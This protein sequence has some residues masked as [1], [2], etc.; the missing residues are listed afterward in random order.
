M[1]KLLTTSIF[2]MT[3][4]LRRGHKGFVLTP[5]LA[6]M[7]IFINLLFIPGLIQG[8]VNTN[9]QQIKK[10]FTSDMVLSPPLTSTD[11]TEYQTTLDQIRS[12]H[13][14]AAATAP[15]QI[16]NRI[17]I[18]DKGNYWTVLAVDPVSFQKTFENKITLGKFVQDN[19]QPEIILGSR[20][21]GNGH[22]KQ[23]DFSTSLGGV[24]Q[25]EQVTVLTYSQGDKD[26]TIQGVF[27]NN[28]YDADI[29]AYI[30]RTAYDKI[31]PTGTNRA[32]SIYVRLKQGAKASTV[33]T[34]IHKIAPDL[35]I[36]DHN[37]IGSNFSD[38]IN[39]F[40]EISKIISAFA[41]LV[42]AIVIFIVTYIELLQRRK[43]V[44]IQRALGIFPETIAL[45][46]LL[47]TLVSTSI[48]LTLGWLVYHFAIVA[49]FNAQP[50]QL[51]IGDVKLVDNPSLYI[52]YGIL[53]LVIA[54]AASLIPTF[55]AIKIPILDAIWGT[56]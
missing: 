29:R 24:K 5:I 13:G 19:D 28:F 7:I 18:G 53:L 31:D 30:S 12:I 42:A 45:T 10:V 4:Q 38:Q 46:H 22:E 55:R 39:T 20:I 43:Q 40:R 35:K 34:E 3:R 47:R 14:V 9:D 44:G 48:G 52:N 49:Y 54:I 33:K 17:R 21:A 56:D 8:A 23:A 26:F 41:L 6:M 11:I 27:D 1:L 36:L 37:Q 16:G 50:F 25:D 51:A 2:I 32:T 15:L